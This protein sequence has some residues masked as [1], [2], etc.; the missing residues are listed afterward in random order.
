MLY[1][2]MLLSMKCEPRHIVSHMSRGQIFKGVEEVRHHTH[3][4]DVGGREGW[5]S[6]PW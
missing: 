4:V 1:K 5:T 6:M 3:E 2:Q